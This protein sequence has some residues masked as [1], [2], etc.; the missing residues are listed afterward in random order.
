MAMPR[1]LPVVFVAVGGVLAMKAL[2]SLESMPDVLR[3]V[4]F[5]AEASASPDDTTDVSDSSSASSSSGAASSASQSSS[6]S[7]SASPALAAA[8][9]GAATPAAAVAPACATSLD[10]LARQAGMSASELQLLQS[11]GVRRAQLDQR[12]QQLNARERLIE[13]AETKLDAR[14][15]QLDSLRT[16]VQGLLDQ[17][18]A[19]ADAD[20]ARMVKVYESMKPKDA[21]AVFTQMSDEVRLPIAAAMKERSLAAVLAAMP[22]AAAKDLTEKLTARMKG[23]NGLQGQLDRVSAGAP[24]PAPAAQRR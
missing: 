23:A 12:E 4:A 1:Y 2:T 17:A 6:V 5:A 8:A 18:K 7:E 3:S 13:T 14:I 19:Q 20:T 24:Q 22:P 16:Q 9:E 21:A 11:L 15:Q 10:D